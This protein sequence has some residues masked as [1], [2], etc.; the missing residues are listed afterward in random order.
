MRTVGAIVEE[1]ERLAP[2][3]LAADWDNVGLLLGDR[4]AEVRRVMTCL[5]V[6]PESAVEAIDGEAQLIVTH[7]PVLFRA[8]KRLTTDSPEGRMLCALLK[9]GV[10][11]FS[12]HTAYDDTPG[13][14]ND[15]LAVRLG[16][17]EVGPLR[18]SEGA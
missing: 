17:R 2:L 3:A 11:V 15:T 4:N 8:V 7:H 14:I 13:G 6:T 16:L 5:T 12:A 9:A 10:A 1:L 18:K